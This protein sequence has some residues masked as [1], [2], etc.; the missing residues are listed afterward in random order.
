MQRS[1]TTIVTLCSLTCL[2][3]MPTPEAF[4]K[5]ANK[6]KTVKINRANQLPKVALCKKAQ[7]YF[8]GKCRTK[9]WIKRKLKPRK[10]GV[11]HSVMTPN[12]GTKNRPSFERQSSGPRRVL[13][14]K[15]GRR[16]LGR[17]RIEKE[18]QD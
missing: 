1:L 5:R 6:K 15:L 10:P 8:D 13:C 17:H 18:E 14:L 4:A 9:K 7:V 16:G 12:K 3:F 11:L 2:M